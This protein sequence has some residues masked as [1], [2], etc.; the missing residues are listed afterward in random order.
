MTADPAVL[1]G[2]DSVTSG[3]EVFNAVITMWI[4]PKKR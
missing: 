3:E 2:V 4:S 1:T